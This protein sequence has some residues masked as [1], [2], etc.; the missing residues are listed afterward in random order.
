MIHGH[1]LMYGYDHQE[2]LAGTKNGYPIHDDDA[3]LQKFVARFIAGPVDMV[4]SR[5][6]FQL[7]C[8][9]FP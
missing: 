5:S 6:L 7:L 1:F 4:V 3:P 8:F 9:L 2:E